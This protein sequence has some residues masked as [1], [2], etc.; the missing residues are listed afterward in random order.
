MPSPYRNLNR[1]YEEQFIR[2][3]GRGLTGIN[4]PHGRRIN[5]DKPYYWLGIAG[6]VNIVK[7]GNITDQIHLPGPQNTLTGAIL[8]ADKH[9]ANQ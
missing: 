4:M 1:A 7:N 5:P 9:E 2:D 3:H 6:L 8:A